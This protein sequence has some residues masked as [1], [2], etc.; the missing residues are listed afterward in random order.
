MS[1]NVRNDF[2][3]VNDNRINNILYECETS[4]YKGSYGELNVKEIIA[5]MKA[6]I[7]EIKRVQAEKDKVINGLSTMVNEDS[8]KED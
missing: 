7:L 4:L 5:V 6:L 2:L 1:D 3:E 8:K